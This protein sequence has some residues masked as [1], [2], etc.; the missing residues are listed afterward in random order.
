[1]KAALLRTP[2]ALGGVSMLLGL[3]ALIAAHLMVPDDRNLSLCPQF[4]KGCARSHA[5]DALAA[6]GWLLLLVGV[7]AL[8]VVAVRRSRDQRR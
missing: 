4:G 8:V 5:Y 1:M 7:I 2:L 6:A 3:V